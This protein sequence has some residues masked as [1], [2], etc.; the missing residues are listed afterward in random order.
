MRRKLAVAARPARRLGLAICAALVA[1]LVQGL[2][3]TIGIVQM[4]FV[5]IP[6]TGLALAAADWGLPWEQEPA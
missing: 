1:V 2:F 4:T 6:F 5:W 3:D